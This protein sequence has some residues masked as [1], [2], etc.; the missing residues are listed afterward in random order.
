MR[1]IYVH[2]AYIYRGGTSMEERWVFGA[3]TYR[4]LKP[5][6]SLEGPERIEVRYE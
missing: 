5:F 4:L 6:R 2:P 1:T 3:L